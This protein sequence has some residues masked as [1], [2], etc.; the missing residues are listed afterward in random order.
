MAEAAREKTE[1][2]IS[3]VAELQ[4]R[5]RS[6]IF[7][8][9]HNSHRAHIQLS[10]FWDVVKDREKFRNIDT[11]EI[12]VH[13]PGGEADIAYQL[14]RFFRRH[15]KRVN[16]IVPLYSKSA[17][18]LLCLGAD[19]IYMGELAELGPLDSQIFDPVERGHRPLSPLDEFKSMEF[20]REYAV[21][22][23]GY[24]TLLFHR[25]FELS[26]K[27]SVHEAIPFVT[28]MVRPLYERVDP[29]EVGEHR[30]VLAVGEEY[31]RRLLAQTKHPEAKRIVE[32]LVSKYPSHGFIIDFEEAASLGLPVKRLDKRDEDSILPVL[33]GMID[34]EVNYCGFIEKPRKKRAASRPRKRKKRA[35]QEVILPVEG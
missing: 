35:P 25:Q 8:L 23:L 10:T 14:V 22:V 18:T 6:R 28:G 5:R 4:K 9:V 33:M 29:M 21:E 30:R 31:A 20:L 32:M 27:D 3:V 24:L 34:H 12:L 19:S 16:V 17:A 15:C 1:R 11:L 7:C 26:V 2:F 13:S